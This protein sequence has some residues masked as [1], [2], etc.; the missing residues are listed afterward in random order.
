MN[1]TINYSNKTIS[2]KGAFSWPQNVTFKIIGNYQFW[3]QLNEK[4]IK[5]LMALSFSDISAFISRAKKDDIEELVK[6]STDDR[7]GFTR[8]LYINFIRPAKFS[9][10]LWDHKKRDTFPHGLERHEFQR[11]I[12]EARWLY[13][14]FQY[15]KNRSEKDWPQELKYFLSRHEIPF[16]KK[17]IIANVVFDAIVAIHPE[18]NSIEDYGHFFRNH[19]LEDKSGLKSIMNDYL[20]GIPF[21]EPLDELLKK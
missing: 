1:V 13:A 3:E 2:R 12:I 10:P 9:N 6:Y 8:D 7:R 16:N 18:M 17:R 15:W 11:I 19:L 5:D 14:F 4:A 20:Q 21:R